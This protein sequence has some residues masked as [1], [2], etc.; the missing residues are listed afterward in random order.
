MLEKLLNATFET[1]YL[2]FVSAILIGI[3]GLIMGIIL[4]ISSP[5][6]ILENKYIYFVLNS[7]INT[8]RSIPFIILIIL[9]LPL[10]KILIG[11][12]LGVKGA[13]PALVIGIAPVYAKLVETSLK[14][15]P[16]GI[17]EAIKSCGASSFQI[18]KKVLIPESLVSLILNFTNLLVSIIGYTA[19]A[20]IIGAGGLGNLAFIE[21]FQ[22]NNY[23]ITAYATLIILVL[24]FIVQYIGELIAK[25]LNKR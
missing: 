12:I 23:Y 2:T 5:K 6:Q 19:M 24:V 16:Y 3:F 11:T 18:I 20:G 10:T 17:I 15:I 22:R 1:F 9:L 4:F 13:I 14:E 21:G 7:F 25:T 8:I